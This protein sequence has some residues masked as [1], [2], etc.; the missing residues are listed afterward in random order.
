[1]P[2]LIRSCGVTEREE[3]VLGLSDG[4]HKW[5]IISRRLEGLRAKLQVY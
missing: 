2:D 4:H 5:S 1:V 3:S